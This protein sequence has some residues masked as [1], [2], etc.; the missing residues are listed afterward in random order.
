MSI[1]KQSILK[2]S[3]IFMTLMLFLGGVAGTL[4]AQAETQAVEDTI[5]GHISTKVDMELITQPPQS[6]QPP[7]APQTPQNPQPPQDPQ[8]P[9]PPQAG[10]VYITETGTK[11][12]NDGCRYLEDS[13]IE[14]AIEVAIAQGYT[15]C[16][17]CWG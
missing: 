6:P 14:I 5:A 9:Q 3:A 17:V 11:Y 16:A 13:K 15:A 10:I 2:I 12:H 7:Q 4:S 1:K 8:K